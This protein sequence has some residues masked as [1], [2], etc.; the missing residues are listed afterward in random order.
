MALIECRHLVKQYNQNTVFDGFD[1]SIEK[2]AFCVITGPSGCGKSTLLNMMGLL[3]QPDKGEILLFGQKV[4]P[5]SRAASKL[6]KNEIGYLFQNFALLDDKSVL[7]NLL[8]A[9]EHHPIKDK[10][11]QIAQALAKVGLEGYEKRLVCT[12][13]GGEAQRV[14][15]A[16]LLVKPCSIVLADEPTGSL[17]TDNRDAMYGLL[18]Y[19]HQTGKTIVVVS[20]DLSILSLASQH[21]ELT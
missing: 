5:F 19:L 17:D 10:E 21:I 3:D 9:I 15:V 4:K 16:R 1:L 2:G 20:H 14:A 13:S 7:A 12:L 11:T 8:I 6:L 18:D